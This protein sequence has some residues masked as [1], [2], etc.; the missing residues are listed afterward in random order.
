MTRIIH[1][2]KKAAAALGLLLATLAFAPAA[3]A[4]VVAD[5]TFSEAAGKTLNQTANTGAG[6]GGAGGSWDVA[7]TG[8]STNGSGELNIRNNGGGGSGTRTTYADF[9]PYPGSVTSGTLSLY[10]TFSAWRLPTSGA[11][12]PSFTLAFIEGN[13]F[14]T[15]QFTVAATAGG[16][17]LSGGVDATGNGSA[18]AQTALF[19]ATSTGPLTVRLSVDLA[20]LNYSL[21]Y[22]TGSGFAVL[23][24]GRVDSFTAGINSL[25]LSV[26]G[27]YTYGGDASGTFLAVDRIWVADGPVANVP[28]P[29]A[30]AMLL[31][32][33]ALLTAGAGSK[34][35]AA[36]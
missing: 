19:A 20:S 24:S 31:T 32:G 14:S 29:A 6:V 10:T 16:L 27:D 2:S 35:R 25:R 23:G 33:L 30:A 1:F 9:G 34:R 8:V 22:D 15:A 28:E 18:I 4:V 5:W 12:L 17:R 13:G 26:A 3:R 7:V 21:A 11:G 36:A